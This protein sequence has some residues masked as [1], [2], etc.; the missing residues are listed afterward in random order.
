LNGRLLAEYYC[1]GVIFDHPD[2]L[3][4]ATTAT[5]CTGSNVQE[6]LYDPQGQLNSFW[7]TSSSAW[8]FRYVLLGA[9]HLAF[10]NQGANE[11]FEHPNALGS[12]GMVTQYNGAA[13]SD[14][15]F[16][17][18]GTPWNIVNGTD[19]NWAS[20]NGAERFE[21]LASTPNRDYSLGEGRWLS[22]DPLGGDV[23]NP[24][25][26]NRYAYVL[27]NPTTLVDPSGLQGCRPP[28]TQM[29]SGVCVGNVLQIT[30]ATMGWGPVGG[31]SAW[32]EFGLVFAGGCNSEGECA[33]YIAVDAE[34][35]ANLLVMEQSYPGLVP[36]AHLKEAVTQNACTP[37]I[38][39]AVNNQFGT[40]FTPDDVTNIFQQGGGT[41]LVIVGTGLPAEQ[42]NAIQT[43][44]Y[45]T[46]WATWLTGYGP[47]LHVAGYSSFWDPNANFSNGNVA[48]VD[49]VVLTA[50]IDT[51]LLYN[52]LGALIH[53][54]RDFLHIGG[55]R[56]PCPH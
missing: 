13:L 7:N 15:Q 55:Q 16:Y 34:T 26:L 51:G 5:D 47:N 48:G 23:T 2:E 8:G 46:S 22:P 50:H 12:I 33:T 20:T 3:G 29:G 52:P 54:L 9:R 44:R 49:S 27:N 30:S 14:Q 1:G 43:G 45:T 42:F 28:W 32:N 41:N 56:D 35:L 6:R 19:V 11:S 4:S 10:D 37:K 53:L 24:Q 31:Y 40:N 17:P 38:L 39:S 21:G 18:W 36:P 25:S